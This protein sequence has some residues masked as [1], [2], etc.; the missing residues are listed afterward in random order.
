MLN[1]DFSKRV[2]IEAA[3]AQWETNPSAGVWRKRL[4]KEEA[5]RGHA[6]SIV[7]HDPGA[8]FSTHD[9]PLGEEIPD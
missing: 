7:R 1:M 2:A 4:A 8:R 9:H 5:E 6:T 3:A